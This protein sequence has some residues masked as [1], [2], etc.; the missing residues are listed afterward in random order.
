MTSPKQIR[1]AA[2][3]LPEV[4]ETKEAGRVSYSVRRKP[5]A[6]VEGGELTVWLSSERADE[7]RADHSEATLT[8]RGGSPF[9]IR[10]PLTA[11]NGMH[12]N[13]LVRDAWTHRAPKAL[14]QPKSNAESAEHTLP[15]EL[16]RPATRA[17]TG[18]GITAIDDLSARTRKEVL[19]LHG[20]GP[21]AVQLL[22]RHLAEAGHT[23]AE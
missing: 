21:R 22:E 12:S 18:A 15:A 6:V 5:F 14:T 17:L 20:V 7:V 9:G 16:D 11:I 8:E 1:K 2:T 13:A 19:G 10:I 4:Q 3:Q 23:W